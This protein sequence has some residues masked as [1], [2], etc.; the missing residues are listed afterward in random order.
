MKRYI[1]ITSIATSAFSE[2]TAGI[3]E[4]NVALPIESHESSEPNTKHV[5]L[6]VKTAIV[7]DSSSM[8]AESIKEESGTSNDV[9]TRGESSLSTMHCDAIESDEFKGTVDKDFKNDKNTEH[10]VQPTMGNADGPNITHLPPPPAPPAPIPYPNTFNTLGQF[11]PHGGI[12]G[13]GFAPHMQGTHPP[14]GNVPQF[15]M[16]GGV[17][18]MDHPAFQPNMN[19]LPPHQSEANFMGHFSTMQGG[20]PGFVP[21][22]QDCSNQNL[23]DNTLYQENQIN[24]TSLGLPSSASLIPFLGETELPKTTN[25]GKDE[26]AGNDINEPA[27]TTTPMDM[28]M[29][30]PEVDIIEKMNEEFWENEQKAQD[31]A[32]EPELLPD[33]PVFPVSPVMSSAHDSKST[34]KKSKGDKKKS[35][36]KHKEEPKDDQP[37][38]KVQVYSFECVICIIKLKITL[39]M[40]CGVKI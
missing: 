4:S 8:Q 14:M 7:F 31:E 28:E 27:A 30:S 10:I 1:L 13:V 18:S 40:T 37:K 6:D 35:S 5:I 26:P 16:R 32:Y 9:I 20:P 17:S 3:I 34:V 12:P 23:L 2:T 19:Q 33:E 22:V 21:A 29:S 38:T 25:G 39:R 24:Q 15:P 11:N 36:K